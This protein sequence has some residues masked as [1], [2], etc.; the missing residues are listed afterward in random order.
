MA[1]RVLSRYKVKTQSHIWAQSKS[2][3]NYVER[4]KYVLLSLRTLFFTKL[5]S[6]VN[7]CHLSLN[8]RTFED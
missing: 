2:L 4:V 5:V 3:T 8:L 1:R 7:N 6:Y